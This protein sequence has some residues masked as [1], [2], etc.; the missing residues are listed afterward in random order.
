MT[1]ARIAGLHGRRVW[2][3]RGRPTVEVEVRLVD[4]V[5]GRAIA[6]AGASTGRG[7]A[8]DLRD[9]GDRF[10]GLDVHRAVGSVNHEIAPALKDHDAG[11]QAAVDRLLADLD[12]TPDRSRLGGNALVATSMAVLHAAAASAGVPL[13][14]HLAGG[15]PVRVP[16]PEIQIFGG[17]AHADR[18]VDVQDFMVVCPAAGS[19]S[20]ALDWTAEIY[21]AAGAL[22]RKAGKAQG[23]ADEGGFW[24]AF[25]SNE[26]ALETLT[27]AI[28]SAGFAPSAQ[29]GISLD[30]A[31]SQFG[32]ADGYRLAL[33]DRTLDTSAL[34]DLL[35]GWIEQYPILS[36][37]DPVGEDDHEGMAEFTRRYGHRCQVIGDDYLV[38][39]AKR[40][41]AAATGGT[42]NA[43]L[44][45]PNQAGTVTEAFEALRAGKDAGFGTVVSARSGESE[46]VTI[47][48]LSVGWDAGQLKVGSFTRSERMAKWNEVL[49]IEESLGAAAEFSGW[50]TFPF[51]TQSVNATRQ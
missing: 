19:F 15:R 16:L 50:S 20:E 51:I 8:L 39:N 18:R 45:K 43:V 23:V 27:R 3:S 42:V 38:T 13:W 2:D 40:V 14:R 26:E 48:H 12:G 35:G 31:A 6:P 32:S 21:R 1:D 37:E 10:G 34:I 25:A 36:V 4:G 30:V 46:D 33:D 9:G 44:V 17:G 28:E 24:P 7:E 5:T 22:M 41:E 47:A 49:R 29:V 11:D